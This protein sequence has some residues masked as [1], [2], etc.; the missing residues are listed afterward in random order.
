MVI[1]MSN[2][3]QVRNRN[4][5]YTFLLIAFS[6][7]F[8][9][10]IYILLNNN[11]LEK[12]I[13]LK[14]KVSNALGIESHPSV[15]FKGFEVGKVTDFNFDESLDVRV[16]FYIYE[17]YAKL[18]S[19][20]SVVHPVR[21]P[22]TGIIIDLYIFSSYKGEQG[23]E[24]D[25]FLASSESGRGRVIAQNYNIKIKEPGVNEV[26]RRFDVLLREIDEQNIVNNIGFVA[27]RLKDTVDVLEGEVIKFQSEGGIEKTKY[28][29][30]ELS[31]K[32]S[33]LVYNVNQLVGDFNKR[34]R[35]LS[36]TVDKAE[37]VLENANYLLEGINQNEFVDGKLMPSKYDGEKGIE[38]NE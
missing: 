29:V 10:A 34:G 5:V 27:Q 18:I 8:I 30:A 15:I 35:S 19:S 26:V 22:L 21:N 1:Y 28:S 37:N 13:K 12:K 4:Y 38:I 14:T 25:S 23:L 9:M 24:N 17:K 16:D 31:D 33:S 6:S 20:N 7:F 36:S 3:M 2:N 32:I 11:F